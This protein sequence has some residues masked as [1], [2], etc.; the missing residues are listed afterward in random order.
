VQAAWKN[1]ATA[2]ATLKSEKA[3]FKEE[4]EVGKVQLD[5]RE[6]GLRSASQE[7]DAR[8]RALQAQEAEIAKGVDGRLGEAR[9]A[10]EVWEQGLMAREEALAAREAG[11]AAGEESLRG[12][13]RAIDARLDD[14]EKAT[15]FLERRKDELRR[16]GEGVARG[17]AAP[18]APQTER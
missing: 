14:L 17:D 16:V 3:H 13:E 9:W 7:L 4:V 18:E 2:N 10:L 5:A 15:K 6:A 12:Y 11:L 8:E 1:I